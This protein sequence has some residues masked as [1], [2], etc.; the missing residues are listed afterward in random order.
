[1]LLK[2]WAKEQLLVIEVQN[3]ECVTVQP[4][5]AHQYSVI[6][7][8]GL[9]ADGYDF[10]PFVPE[11]KI[12]DAVG[13]KFVFPHAPVMPISAF[14]GQ[15]APAWFDFEYMDFK[16]NVNEEHINNSVESIQKLIDKELDAGIAPENI[17]VAG[18]S[19]GGV[20]ALYAGLRNEQKLGGILALSTF[21]PSENFWTNVQNEIKIF[22][23][24][25]LMV[26]RTQL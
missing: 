4:K 13:A 23:F 1:M 10:Q 14:G 24:S 22:L 25:W 18:F 6:W 15:M 2:V 5:M 11:L 17:I 20:M 8:H 19:Q 12:P 9:G 16:R 26:H 21:I 7:M 3:L